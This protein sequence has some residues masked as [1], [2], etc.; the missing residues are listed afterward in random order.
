MMVVEAEGDPAG[1][2]GAVREALWSLDSSLPLEEIEPVPSLVSRATAAPRYRTFLLSSFALIAA[3]L[4]GVGAFG[5]VARALFHRARELGIRLAL[6]ATPGRL[7]REEVVREMMAVMI[8]LAGGIVIALI[9][10]RLVTSFL[11]GV[12]AYDPVTYGVAVAS[13]AG[14]GI[15]ATLVATRRIARLDPAKVLRDS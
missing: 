11:F 10:V 14:L 9:G 8:G 4:S 6:G 15:A 7:I 5:V 12:S 2:A 3:L 13:M 1:L